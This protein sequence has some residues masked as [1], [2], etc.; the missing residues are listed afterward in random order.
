MN[1]L[2]LVDNYYIGASGSC[3]GIYCFENLLDGKK[4]VGQGQV[5]KGRKATHFKDLKNNKDSEFFQIAWNEIGKE[6]FRLWIVEECSIELLNERE[7]FWIKELHS[8]VSEWGYNKT[9]GGQCVRGYKHSPETIQKMKDNSGTRGKHPTLETIQKIREANSG[10]NAP[11]LGKKHSEQSIQKMRENHWD[12]S[13]KNN[14]NFG[15]YR[16]PE[17]IEKIR[18]SNTGKKRSDETRQMLRQSHLGNKNRILK[19][20]KVQQIK[21][22]LSIGISGYEIAKQLS[23]CRITVR[24]VKNGWYKDIY[25]I[26]GIKKED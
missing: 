11:M 15:K 20:E 13:G 4:Y 10:E 6:N 17:T 16:S 3:S 7:M 18:K 12:Q 23:I 22:M 26:Q 8:H 19:K 14:S 21:D 1:M 24:K 5:L 25:G 2:L 9:W